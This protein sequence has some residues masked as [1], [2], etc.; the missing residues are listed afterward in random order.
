MLYHRSAT[1]TRS[2]RDRQASKETYYSGKRDLLY[3]QQRDHGEIDRLPQLV[4]VQSVG[5]SE[6]RL[7]S[8]NI[9][10]RRQAICARA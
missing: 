8:K 5:L 7:R 6:M 10:W 4:A 1:S 3:L 2:W 9:E